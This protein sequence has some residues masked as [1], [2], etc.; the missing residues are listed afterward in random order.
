MLQS[1]ADQSAIPRNII[2]LLGGP[3]AGKGTQ[4]KA[5]TS[6]FGIPHISTGQILRSEASAG[7]PLGL[8]AKAAMEA[9]EL[10]G[11][12][13]VNTLVAQ[14]IV[15]EDC[16]AGFVLDGYPR[17]IR[18]AVTFEEGLSIAD[19]QIVLDIA[20]D[21]E[22]VIPRLTARR[23]CG[24]CGS[25]YHLTTSPPRQPGLCDR[26]NRSLVQRSDDREEVIRERFKAY[27]DWTEPLIDFYRRKGIYFEV[28]GMQAP[29]QVAGD[30]RRI[31]EQEISAAAQ[32][33]RLQA[34]EGIC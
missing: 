30:I 16:Q 13:L 2:I 21:L 22:K 7:T 9:G 25:I 19:R 28:D 27:A 17:D 15:K 29:A 23:T 20:V 26:C 11:D 32:G 33:P 12:D 8:R 34:R 5:I 4:A 24:T 18:Q 6:E 3:G 14:R 31:L 1:A 10:V